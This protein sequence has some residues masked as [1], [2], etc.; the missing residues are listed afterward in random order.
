MSALS[1]FSSSKKA[2]LSICLIFVSLFN[3]F[4]Q[5][6]TIP[7]EEIPVTSE[8]SAKSNS[9][10]SFN[11]ITETSIGVTTL[12]M[13]GVS[14]FCQHNIPDVNNMSFNLTDVNSFDSALAQPYSKALDTTGDCLL[15]LSLLTPGV[16]LSTSTNQYLTIGVMYAEALAFSYSAK[17]MTKAL[18]SRYRPYMYFDNYPQDDVISG[19]FTDSF[20]SGHTTLAFTAAGFA[21]SVFCEYF[22][23]SKWKLPVILGSYALSTTTA[24]LRLCSGNHFL[25][26]VITGAAIGS[27]SG[28]GIPFL[29]KLSNK[30]TK[31]IKSDKID[32]ISI[33]M[34][35]NTLLFVLKM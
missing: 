16:L 19:D 7:Q 31:D 27:L 21:T 23:D 9:P 5:E 1:Y 26:D 12:S 4:S 10:Y 13:L 3:L 8:S 15:V 2:L 14:Y 20:P 24:I 34:A 30:L 29:H 25:T 33:Q 17:N 28:Y 22:P 6:N 35:P 18:I 32:E 11:W